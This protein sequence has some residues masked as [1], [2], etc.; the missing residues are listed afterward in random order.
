MIFRDI[1]IRTAT[2][3]DIDYVVRRMRP[4]DRREVYA[5]R[6]SDDAESLIAEI[7]VRAPVYAP[8]KAIAS[9]L[10]PSPIALVGVLVMSPG[11]GIAHMIATL[12]WPRIAKSASRWIREMLI[13][14]CLAAGLARVEVRALSE[15]AQNCRWLESLGARREAAVP[16]LDP[17]G[18]LFVQYAWTKPQQ[19]DAPCA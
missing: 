7:R 6:F 8:L 10:H 1:A 14:D 3:D 5:L 2:P 9:T 19:G 4:M 13:P 17:M 11:V 12:E 15:F 18:G 16:G